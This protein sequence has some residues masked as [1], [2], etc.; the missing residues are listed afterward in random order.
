[1]SVWKVRLS[2][3]K[4]VLKE[5][6]KS[7]NSPELSI[8]QENDRFLLISSDFNQLRNAEEVKKKADK[9]LS[10][11]NGA[12]RLTIGMMENISIDAVIETNECGRSMTYVNFSDTIVPSA[13]TNEV[14]RRIDGSIEEFHQADIIPI[15]VRLANNDESVDKVL[16][17]YEKGEDYDNLYRIFEVVRKDVGGDENIIRNR[18]ATSK[19]IKRFTRT[20]NSAEILGVHARHGVQNTEPPKNPLQLSEAQ[21]FIKSLVRN[22]LKS[23]GIE[24]GPPIL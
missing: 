8:I 16:I 2:G 1:V 23:K 22:W 3:D 5:L 14:I 7:F 10:L 19:Q 4:S 11:I 17:L 9:L 15:L 20:A 13:S 12:F 6:V 18:W 21:S 24:S